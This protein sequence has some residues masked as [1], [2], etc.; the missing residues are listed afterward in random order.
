MARARA[1]SLRQKVAR[2]KASI[3]A[4]DPTG[5]LEDAAGGGNSPDEGTIKVPDGTTGSAGGNNES[6]PTTVGDGAAEG[7]GTGDGA[8]EVEGEGAGDGTKEP[9]P[10][11]D[12][13]GERPPR[14]TGTHFSLR[15][16]Q[17]AQVSGVGPTRHA[18]WPA[19]H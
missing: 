11:G 7:A 19:R 1:I 9:A 17:L 16:A 14:A 3:S 2:P 18:V 4:N 15:Q 13:R 12:T 6:P 8:E 5:E 10:V